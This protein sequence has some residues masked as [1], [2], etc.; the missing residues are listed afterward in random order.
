MLN[1]CHIPA[2]SARR[3]PG[4]DRFIICSLCEQIRAYARRA[5]ARHHSVLALRLRCRFRPASAF[6]SASSRACRRFATQT[7]PFAYLPP[8]S[9]SICLAVKRLISD[10]PSAFIS[11][12]SRFHYSTN[13]LFC[14]DIVKSAAFSLKSAILTCSKT[15][16]RGNCARHPRE[17]LHPLPIIISF[18]D[19]NVNRLYRILCFLCNFF[20]DF[21]HKISVKPCIWGAA[22]VQCAVFICFFR[23][24][25][26]HR[27]GFR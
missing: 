2:F 25:K 14:T 10:I 4:S 12:F 17:P 6:A 26:C 8:F 20:I 22:G 11:F 9:V 16:K 23:R 7:F 18:L 1:K 21:S 27:R 3:G 19:K 15:K 5:P 13:S 24:F